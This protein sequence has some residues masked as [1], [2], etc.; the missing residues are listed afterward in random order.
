[1]YTF[2]A[3]YDGTGDVND[4]ANWPV[5]PNLANNF[6]SINGLVSDNAS[7][8]AQTMYKHVLSKASS[9]CLAINTSPDVTAA[10]TSTPPPPLAGTAVYDSILGAPKCPT[11]SSSCDSGV[12]LNGRGNFGGSPEPSYPNTLDTC[13]D[14]GSGNYH[15]DESL[16]KIK[17]STVTG[18]NLQP[19]ATV[20]IEA[21]VY[22][23]STTADSADFYYSA[24]ATNP[25]WTFIATSKPT[26]A[27]AV[28]V[29]SAQYILP[30][31]DV[32]AVRVVFRYNGAATPCPTGSYDDVDDLVFAVGGAATTT[33][34][35]VSYCFVQSLL[36]NTYHFANRISSS[37]VV[38]IPR[39]PQ[40]R[41]PPHKLQYPEWQSWWQLS[42][43]QL[44]PKKE[45]IVIPELYWLDV[46]R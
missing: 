19:G 35:T 7:R 11:V 22:T 1:M 8:E 17:V 21:T 27:K 32:Q 18:G 4:L 2:G 28:N 6:D 36:S 30:A 24:S 26:V 12:L 25:Q 40:L 45:L 31:G 14:G 13:T 42:V 46:E 23:Y 33:T 5:N 41:R 15:A 39:P 29:I 38:V 10:P 34:S 37:A 3:D 43:S 9:G 44:V 16:D 20:K